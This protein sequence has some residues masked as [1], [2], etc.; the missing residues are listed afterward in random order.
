MLNSCRFD[1]MNKLNADAVK[2]ILAID[3]ANQ[4]ILSEQIRR[5]E[6]L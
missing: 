6:A 2:Q 5:I 3:K 4:V 1:S